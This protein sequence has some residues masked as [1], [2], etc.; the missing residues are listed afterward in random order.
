MLKYIK[1]ISNMQRMPFWL[2]Y[3]L[4]QSL[5]FQS[6][7]TPTKTFTNISKVSG[8]LDPL[9]LRSHLRVYRWGRRG[10]E[11]IKIQTY[12]NRGR[13]SCYCKHS[14]KYLF[15]LVP[16]PKSTCYIN[17]IFRCFHQNTCLLIITVFG[18]TIL[19]IL[20]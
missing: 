16:S 13:E 7:T 3:H 19:G 5:S 11:A 15:S 4:N 17:Q 9:L 2:Q 12:A 18:K 1:Y 20:L 14:R 6:L 10:G 8:V